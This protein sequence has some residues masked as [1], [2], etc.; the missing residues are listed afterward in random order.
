M[1]SCVGRTALLLI[2]VT[3]VTSQFYDLFQG[4]K[5]FPT[6]H[7]SYGSYTTRKPEKTYRQTTK[8]EETTKAY[9]FDLYNNPFLPQFNLDRNQND[10]KRKKNTTSTYSTTVKPKKKTTTNKR[11]QNL[12]EYNNNNIYD[13]KINDV[14]DYY[15]QKPNYNNYY[16]TENP[17]NKGVNS[18][19]NPYNKGVRPVVTNG[20]PITNRP[21]TKRPNYVVT[22]KPNYGVNA[23]PKDEDSI[24]FPDDDATP[25]IIIGPDEDYMSNVEKKRYIELAER[26]CDE[27]KALGTKAVQAIPL[28]PR[29][30]PVQISVRKCAPT[31]V[32]LVVGGKVVDIQEFPHMAL[33]GWRKIQSA[34]YSWKCGGSLVSDQFILTAAHC[35]FQDRDNTVVNG[36]PS[37][38]QL[39]SS[40]LDD[41]GALVV[42]VAAVIRHP[43]YKLPKSYYDLALVK[44][45]NTIKFSEV[46]KPAC[47]GA[48]PAVG[49][50]IIATGWGRTE[51]G[52]DQSL[53]LRSVSLPVWDINRCQEVLGTS[54]KLPQGP[55]SESQ[56]CAGEERGGKDTC[57]GD[58]GGPAQLQEDCIWRLVGVTS[59]GRSC[60]AAETPGLYAKLQRAFIAS[61]IFGSQ[62]IRNYTDNNQNYGN[63][64]N[65]G[66]NNGNYGN[67]NANYGNS[68]ANYG[69]NNANSGS[70]NNNYDNNY[71][72]NNRQDSVYNERPNNANYN[73]RRPGNS[74]DNAQR[75]DRNV[76]NYPGSQNGANNR[77][78]DYNRGRPYNQQDYNNYDT[79]G[80][81]NRQTTQKPNRG[82]VSSEY[83]GD[84]NSQQNSQSYYTTRKPVRNNNYDNKY[85]SQNYGNNNRDQT[86]YNRN[87]NY[88]YNQPTQRTQDNYNDNR[89]SNVEDYT[90]NRPWWLT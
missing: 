89:Q 40:Y 52:G 50:P 12:Q 79:Q 31:T 46:V 62:K 5:P 42:K 55:S 78:Q 4:F 17:F 45:V 27:Y 60:G 36:P 48:A 18:Y 34:G 75:P 25:E 90:V 15:T 51:Y 35:S 10:Y 73:N 19:E 83:N 30:E 69:N 6:H 59:L 13:G 33:L 1:A 26:K 80:S 65:Y 44:L 77:E 87:D 66:N 86:N 41:P 64:D 8:R 43:K 63:S 76:N 38:V 11:A 57:Q 37:A 88:G 14:G 54:R 81:N 61:Q 24:A 68:N 2:L 49:T 39:G 53:E 74:Q 9:E 84:Y 58:S 56:I 20:P 3:S 85:N 7:P 28:L 16:T 22:S 23:R 82:I 67:N 47:L 72:S 70:N 29:P 21:V 32:P 71:G